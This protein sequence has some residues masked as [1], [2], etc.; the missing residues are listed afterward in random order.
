MKEASPET[1]HAGVGWRGPGANRHLPAAVEWVDAAP[2]RA[3]RRGHPVD[4]AGTAGVAAEG[5]LS[6]AGG[7]VQLGRELEEG[8]PVPAGAYVVGELPWWELPR[9]EDTL[10]RTPRLR[11]QLR[12]AVRHGV[13]VRELPASA[14]APGTAVR[15]QVEALVGEWLGARRM[16]PLHFAAEVAPFVD[17]V[18]RRVFVAEQQGQPCAALFALPQPSAGAWVLDH[19]VRRAGA[20]NGTSELLVDAAF[21]TA[22]ADGACRATLGLCALS[23]RVPWPLRW[24][25]R[26]FRPLYDFEGLH[27]F[28]ARLHPHAWRRVLVEH[29]GQHALVGTL[30]AL[31]AFAGGSLAHFA[32]ETLRWRLRNGARRPASKRAP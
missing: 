3:Q 15:A 13:R 11:A 2:C 17:L 16:P 6:D 30:R 29:P 19:L 20:P 7:W 23:G 1:A 32:W 12:R 18:Q 4:A 28:R 14:L 22:R 26:L 10:A 25:R 9:W 5:N 21:R 8:A 31:R 27:A 24:A